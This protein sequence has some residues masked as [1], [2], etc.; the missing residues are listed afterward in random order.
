MDNSD[1][2][3]YYQKDMQWNLQKSRKLVNYIHKVFLTMLNISP[4]L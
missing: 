3:F 4:E 1:L 2:G